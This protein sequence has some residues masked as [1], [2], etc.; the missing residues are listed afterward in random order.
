VLGDALREA[1]AGNGGDGL[2]ARFSMLTWP[3]ITSEWVNVDR[4]PDSR[5]YDNA[6]TVF[7]RCETLDAT[8]LRG[9]D[10]QDPSAPGLRFDDAAQAEFDTWRAD[11]ERLQ[12]ASEDH[13]ALVAHRDKFRKLVPSLALICHLADNPNGGRINT[14]SLLRALG[15]AEYGDSHARRAYASVAQPEIAGARELLRRI[16]AKAIPERFRARDIYLKG[17]AR[18][19]K[20]EQVHQAARLLVDLDYLSP[21]QR[22]EHA[23]GR[24][25]SGYI[26]NP[27][28]FT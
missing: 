26:V 20:P 10:L 8:S 25:P 13:P 1:V 4:F 6:C 16:R 7:R 2:L 18:L 17:W 22:D 21:E 19:S 9:V 15:W 5:A 28:L 12:R 11:F 24:P 14:S 27:R 23:M 3:D